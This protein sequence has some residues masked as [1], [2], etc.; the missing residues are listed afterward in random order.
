MEV[1]R[2]LFLEAWKIKQAAHRS[3]GIPYVQT[4]HLGFPHRLFPLRPNSPICA[5]FGQSKGREKLKRVVMKS[6][7]R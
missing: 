1:K 4:G 2:L 3:R 7:Q 5:V 6:F